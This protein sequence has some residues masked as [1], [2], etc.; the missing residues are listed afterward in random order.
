MLFPL[1]LVL[2]K[3]LEYWKVRFSV[4][5]RID[6]LPPLVEESFQSG[7]L[8]STVIQSMYP[9]LLPW[10]PLTLTAPSVSPL[11]KGKFTK[12]STR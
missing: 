7:S 4:S 2:P 9:P 11:L 8:L 10:Y 5:A 1:P 6:S 12:A 3:I